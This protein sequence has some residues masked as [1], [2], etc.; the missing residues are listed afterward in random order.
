[1]VQPD[2][3]IVFPNTTDIAAMNITSLTY[4]FSQLRASDGGQYTCTATVNIPEVGIAD[5]KI[6]TTENVTVASEHVHV[7]IVFVFVYTK[8]NI[9]VHNITVY[10]HTYSTSS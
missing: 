5:I 8:I 9:N 7:I 6:S 2:L 4:T 10:T 3:E 1:M